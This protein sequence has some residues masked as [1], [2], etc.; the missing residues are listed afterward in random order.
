MRTL[1][2]RSG[3]IAIS[4][5]VIVVAAILGSHVAAN[6]S[7]SV[8]T[9][10]GP[11]SE[12][13]PAGQT[14]SVGHTRSSNLSDPSTWSNKQLAAQLI[15]AGVQSNSLSQTHSWS[16]AGIAG[17]VLFGTPPSNLASKIKQTRDKSPDKRLVVASDE[18]GGAVQRLAR[19]VGKYPSAAQIGRTKSVKQTEALARGLGKKL[20]H[21]GVNSDLAPVADLLYKGSWT[22]RDGR[23]FKSNPKLNGK[24]VSAFANG[25]QQAG[26]SATVKLWP[27][28]GAV[29]DTHVGAGRTPAW[30]KMK[31]RD[32]VP[33]GTAFKSGTA[34]VMVSHA[35]IPGLTGKLPATQST[36]AY[37]AL[38][39]Q[40][41]NNV[42]IMT[43]SLA[44]AV[45]TKSMRQSQIQA[46]IRALRS[47][48]DLALIQGSSPKTAIS[49]IAQ[50]IASGKINRS[51]AVASAKRVL[52][53]QLKFR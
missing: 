30:S 11:A 44:M 1:V 33:F 41:G 36:K 2:T 8:S 47:G 32:L 40:S 50:A 53:W 6:S 29:A 9:S 45:V 5:T 14:R 35:R 15:L 28:G 25:L 13:A 24:Y 21:L 27:G 31:A 49:K 18:E 46:A 19:L 3:A 38:R 16:K 23:A 43:D 52:A 7:P 12:A 4:V 26:V 34:S 20:K 42:V 10:Q 51:A 37:S 22:A 39:Q 17:V 48:A